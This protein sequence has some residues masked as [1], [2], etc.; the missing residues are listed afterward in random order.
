MSFLLSCSREKLL[1]CAHR[2]LEQLLSPS[3]GEFS[4]LPL[5]LDDLTD[6]SIIE[7]RAGAARA[8]SLFRGPWR[9]LGLRRRIVRHDP[10]PRRFLRWL[11]NEPARIEEGGREGTSS[12]RHWNI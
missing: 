6:Q 2:R 11:V 9:R 12:L 7:V 1:V 5:D 10:W 4:R 8:A 3:P